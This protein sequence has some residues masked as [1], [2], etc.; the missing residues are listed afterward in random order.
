MSFCRPS[1]AA[2]TIPVSRNR[3]GGRCAARMSRNVG[4]GGTLG[5]RSAI[6]GRCG[7]TADRRTNSERILQDV[8]R[9]LWVA[10]PNDRHQ[11]QPTPSRHT[12]ID[13]NQP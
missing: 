4:G 13:R 11:K 9:I 12:L 5:L 10:G 2:H 1:P 6:V 8:G 3:S 7:G